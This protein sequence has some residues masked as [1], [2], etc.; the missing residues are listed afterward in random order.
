MPQ[1]LMHG[2]LLEWQTDSAVPTYAWAFLVCPKPDRGPAAAPRA[3]V[4]GKREF[5]TAA[6][7]DAGRLLREPPNC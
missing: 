1:V 7:A 4:T 3:P 5:A 2:L 6:G